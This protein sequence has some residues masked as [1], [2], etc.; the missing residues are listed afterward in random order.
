MVI[1]PRFKQIWQ[2]MG[3]SRTMNDTQFR[4]YK[5]DLPSDLDLPG[6]ELRDIKAHALTRTL[7]V[8]NCDR[9]MA[10][11]LSSIYQT[12]VALYNLSQ[13]S[14]YHS[15]EIVNVFIEKI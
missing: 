4:I 15:D 10:G 3:R 12:L 2:A 8:R 5:S 9:K 7:Y 13:D 14:F 1:V 11:N 6:G